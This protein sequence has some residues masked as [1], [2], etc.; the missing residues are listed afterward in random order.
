MGGVGWA[1]RLVAGF[2]CSAY[3]MSTRPNARRT[4]TSDL[5][6]DEYNIPAVMLGSISLLLLSLLHVCVTGLVLLSYFYLK[7]GPR[8]TCTWDISAELGRSSTASLFSPP[9]PSLLSPPLPSPLPTLAFLCPSGAS[10]SL[11]TREEHCLQAQSCQEVGALSPSDQQGALGL[12]SASLS[13]LPT[14]CH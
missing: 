8:G 13:F 7:V 5:Q 1:V 14:P 12:L 2:P 4:L 3:Q 10:P 6:S 11:Q 9:L